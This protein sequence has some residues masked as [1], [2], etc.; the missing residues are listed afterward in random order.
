M[1]ALNVT[2]NG[3]IVDM[4]GRTITGPVKIVGEL[5][6]SD[7]H[8]GGGP[9]PPG[10]GGSPGEPPSIWDPAF[11]TPP[12]A[13]VPG[14]PG[15]RPPGEGIW[16]PNDPRP[17]PPIYLPPEQTPPELKPPEAPAPGS[18]TTIVPGDY[19]VQPVTP[20]AYITVNWPGI[21]PCTV[22]QPLTAQPKPQ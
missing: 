6:Y 8:V 14:V 13:N 11:P 22:A 15:Y 1:A 3:V 18:P 9:T 16:G 2:L 4:Y 20:P 10:S 7:R 5:M 12:I 17:T 19:T 21:G